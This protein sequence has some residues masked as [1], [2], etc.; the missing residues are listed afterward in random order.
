MDEQWINH[1]EVLRKLFIEEN[2]TLDKVMDIMR[3]DYGFHAMK[4]LYNRWFSRWGFVKYK[5]RT[6]TQVVGRRLIRHGRPDEIFG[7]SSDERPVYAPPVVGYLARRGAQNIGH[8]ALAT[9]IPPS[10]LSPSK[11]C[12]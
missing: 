8:A 2:M 7:V 5:K 6:G 10:R 4:K 11:N 9:I 1:K 12:K 3:D